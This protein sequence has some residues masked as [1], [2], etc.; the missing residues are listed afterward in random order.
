MAGSGR[1]ER[2]WGEREFSGA[3]NTDEMLLETIVTYVCFGDVLS[4][5][6]DVDFIHLYLH[7]PSGVQDYHWRRKR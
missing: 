1:W 6:E 2:V 7:R 5:R 3:F 4:T